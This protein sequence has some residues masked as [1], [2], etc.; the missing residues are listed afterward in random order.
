MV[1]EVTEFNT[2][3]TEEMISRVQQRINELEEQE[4]K[5]L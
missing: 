1:G 5:S 3:V 2:V 4:V